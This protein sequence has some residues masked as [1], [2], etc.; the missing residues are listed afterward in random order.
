M[1]REKKKKF[2]HV[3]LEN[4]IVYMPLT[5]TVHKTWRWSQEWPKQVDVK[6][7][8]WTTS[9]VGLCTNNKFT[10]MHGMEHLVCTLYNLQLV[11]NFPT[12]NGYCLHPTDIS[13]Y[14]MILQPA[15]KYKPPASRTFSL[16]TISLAISSQRTLHCWWKNTDRTEKGTRNPRIR[17]C[18]A[19][20]PLY[21]KYSL[22]Y[23][24]NFCECKLG[25]KSPMLLLSSRA[26]PPRI[27]IASSLLACWTV[28]RE[29]T[30]ADTNICNDVVRKWSREWMLLT[31]RSN[32]FTAHGLLVRDTLWTEQCDDG[33]E[34]RS[35]RR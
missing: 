7:K 35:T 33:Y 23:S 20:S 18:I 30:T 13:Q 25:Q 1:S 24:A 19:A 12:A 3:S 17:I 29:A 31:V 14:Y 8:R 5:C 11:C 4:F 6:N 16:P 32:T 9:L 15:L 26:D 22:K 21:L 28:Q 10:L 34:Y 2:V 27:D